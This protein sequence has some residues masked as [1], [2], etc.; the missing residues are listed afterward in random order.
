MLI[1]DEVVKHIQLKYKLY[2]NSKDTLEIPLSYGFE[3]TLYG[4]TENLKTKKTSE[5][6]LGRQ[7][8]E[9]PVT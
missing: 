6:S 8:I 9:L 3:I 4:S 2:V 1:T 7:R 5:L